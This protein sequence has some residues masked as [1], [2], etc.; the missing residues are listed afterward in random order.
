MTLQEL[1]DFLDYLRTESR[2]FTVNHIRIANTT[3]RFPGARLEVSML[4]T[5]ARYSEE[6]VA[7][8]AATAASTSR[9]GPRGARRNPFMRGGMRGGR[10]GAAPAGGAAAEESW[11]QG[12]K[13]KYLPF[14]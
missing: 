1:T 14:L 2:Y 10:P 11:W 9:A 12:F 4:L 13:K 7:V 8:I 6:S 3:L 5:Q